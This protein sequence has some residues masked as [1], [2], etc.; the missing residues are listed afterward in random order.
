M[1]DER[2]YAYLDGK[3]WCQEFLKDFSS[4]KEFIK[5]FL[6]LIAKERYPSHMSSFIRGVN[7]CLNIKK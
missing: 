4:D 3:H 7:E 5:N 6:S 1:K 2:L